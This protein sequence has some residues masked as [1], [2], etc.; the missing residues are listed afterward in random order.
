M[1]KALP[2]V[3]RIGPSMS[4]P[5]FLSTRLLVPPGRHILVGACGTVTQNF[6]RSCNSL[7]ATQHR[8]L[9][10][11]DPQFAWCFQSRKPVFLSNQ[12]GGIGGSYNQP[13]TENDPEVALT[14][15]TPPEAMWRPLAGSLRAST[16]NGEPPKNDVDGS[17]PG[18]AAGRANLLRLAL[19][20]R[21]NRNELDTG[22]TVRHR[23]YS[24][25][26]VRACA[27]RL[28]AG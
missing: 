8:Q 4:M 28:G 14:Q 23:G 27:D 11:G 7:N 12:I 6:A 13:Q 21:V 9:I 17:G 1:K 5:W 24:S 20:C 16:R 2:G 19:R 25:G 3:H 26:F 22:P 15:K 18:S 10:S